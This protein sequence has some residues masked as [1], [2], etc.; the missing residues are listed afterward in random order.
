MDHFIPWA[1]YPDNGIE[2]LVLAD[3]RCD[4][5]KRDFLAASEHVRRWRERNVAESVALA[6][7]ADALRWETH[8]DETLG[9]ARGLYLRLPPGARLW[10]RGPEFCPPDP[11]GL[12]ETLA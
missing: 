2:N 3:G 1:R 9:V 5:A 11:E 12:Q 4:G 7:I 6:G 10:L 8:A